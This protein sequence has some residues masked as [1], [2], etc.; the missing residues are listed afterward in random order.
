M[1]SSCR[2][3]FTVRML[4]SSYVCCQL[5]P[6]SDIDRGLLTDIFNI[7]ICEQHCILSYNTIIYDLNSHSTM[8]S[9]CSPT[10]KL[11][12][13]WW[14]H[15]MGTFSALLVLCAGNASVTGEFRTQRPVTRS[16]D[17]YFDLCLNK[18]S[19]IQS[20]GWWFETLLRSLWCHCNVQGLR[21]WF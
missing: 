16:F 7:I 17:V 14:R 2:S 5:T 8:M 21:N 3:K 18:Q 9:S 13:S 19:S 6:S 1:T 10:R 15:E 20:W 12:E 4:T 11:H